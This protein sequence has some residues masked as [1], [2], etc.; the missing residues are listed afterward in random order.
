MPFFIAIWQNALRNSAGTPIDH[1]GLYPF[2]Y[3]KRTRKKWV[4]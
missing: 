3:K 2:N 4:K 1:R